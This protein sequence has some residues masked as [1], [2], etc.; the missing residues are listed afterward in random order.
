VAKYLTNGSTGG[1]FVHI[2]FRLGFIV[3]GFVTCEDA[4]KCLHCSCVSYF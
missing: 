2:Q 1:L 4:R 3:M